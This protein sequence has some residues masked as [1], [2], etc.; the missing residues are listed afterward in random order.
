MNILAIIM[1]FLLNCKFTQK[2]L[3]YVLKNSIASDR[4]KNKIGIWLSNVKKLESKVRNVYKEY[5][6]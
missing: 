3:N 1:I 2:H 4:I 6:D 5:S